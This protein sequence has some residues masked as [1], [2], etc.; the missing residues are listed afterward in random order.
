MNRLLALPLIV[1]GLAPVTLAQESQDPPAAATQAGHSLAIDLTQSS[2]ANLRGP[3]SSD[4]ISAALN[5]PETTL[6]ALS[7]GTRSADPTSAVSSPAMAAAAPQPAAA[8]PKSLY[9][10]D[11][12]DYRWEIAI[13]VTLVRFRSSVYYATAV[14]VNTDIAFFFRPELAV[15]GSVTTAFAPTIFQNEHVKYLGYDGGARYYFKSSRLQPWVHG[16]AGGAHILPQTAL[17]SQNGFEF[18]AGGGADYS[19]SPR[20]AVR[21]EVDYLRTHVFNQWQ[22]NGQG[23]LSFV[24]RF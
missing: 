17:G 13:G 3:Q 14:G 21:A 2:V 1:L 7:F 10:Y 6:A 20:L 18:L 8:S 5:P 9:D 23:S 12:R 11:Q 16:L 24:F 22:N 15:E 19:L 4:W